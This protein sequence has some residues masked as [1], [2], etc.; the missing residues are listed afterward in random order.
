MISLS[1]DF[2]VDVGFDLSAFGNY[3]LVVPQRLKMGVD[4]VRV[5][6]LIPST[7]NKPPY[8]YT[9]EPKVWCTEISIKNHDSIAKMRASGRLARNT[10]ELARSLC[11]PEKTTLE[12]DSI[13]RKFILDAGAYPSPLN[14]MGFPN[15]V[16]TSV[17]NVICHGIPDERPLKSGDIINV[18]ITV[19]LNGVHGDTSATFL[20]GEVDSKGRDLVEHTK[21]ALDLGLLACGPYVPFSEIG[22]VIDRYASKHGYSVSKELTGHG[23][24]AQFHE[25]PLIFHH[26]N[27]EEGIMKPG[28][29]FTVEPIICQGVATSS[30]WPDGWTIVTEDGGRSAQF[31]HTILITHDGI[32]ILTG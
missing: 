6:Q 20:V 10:L 31:E 23:I 1:A 27:N 32:E 21:C 14:Y 3:Q 19:F 8:A 30:L 22:R 11:I 7:I 2:G 26:E 16:C 15:S 5:D 4:E 9:K 13:L 17:N 12:I 28:M 24:G 29:T 18:D 25:A